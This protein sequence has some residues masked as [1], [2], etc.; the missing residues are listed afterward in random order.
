[1]RPPE[2]RETADEGRQHVHAERRSENEGFAPDVIGRWK[3]RAH[4]VGQDRVAPQPVPVGEHEVALAPEDE[5]AE[6]ERHAD[7]EA[8]KGQGLSQDRARRRRR[9]RGD[10]AQRSEPA[11]EQ[12]SGRGGLKPRREQKVRKEDDRRCGDD[13]VPVP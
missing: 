6:G 10:E 4:Q 7:E 9:T 3:R 8:R 13:H 12:D 2:A 1:M 11:R 5:E